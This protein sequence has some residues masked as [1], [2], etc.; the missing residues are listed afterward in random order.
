MTEQLAAKNICEYAFVVMQV[1]CQQFAFTGRFLAR[2]LHCIAEAAVE[3]DRMLDAVAFLI[4]F[5]KLEAANR[6]VVD[7]LRNQILD[8]VTD[9]D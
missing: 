2:L 3:E 5:N 9:W 4:V 8:T 1:D 6:L 7:R